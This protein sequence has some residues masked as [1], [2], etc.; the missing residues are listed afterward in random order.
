L[1][2]FDD[3]SIPSL[4]PLPSLT[5]VSMPV[6]KNTKLS[7]K[8]LPISIVNTR[9]FKVLLETECVATGYMVHTLDATAVALAATSSPE[10]SHSRD[11]ELDELHQLVLKEYHDYLDVFSKSKSKV[12]PPHCPYD[13]QIEL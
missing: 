4:P 8:S 10:P 2:L 7:D 3:S 13:H 9:A 12:L 5:P 11:T 6:D 1:M